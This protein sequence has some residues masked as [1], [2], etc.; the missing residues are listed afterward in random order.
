MQM[1]T[2]EKNISL[3]SIVKYANVPVHPKIAESLKFICYCKVLHP[4]SRNCLYMY[5]TRP[6]LPVNGFEPGY[7]LHRFRSF[8]A[9]K[10]APS[11]R[12]IAVAQ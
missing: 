11:S 12:N 3:T 10:A 5:W 1:R 4:F 2:F 7:F 9:D 6:M 8:Y